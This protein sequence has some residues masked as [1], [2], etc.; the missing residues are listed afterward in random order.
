MLH[1]CA[2]CRYSSAIRVNYQDIRGAQPASQSCPATR[3][4]KIDAK[5]NI[6]L[7]VQ[8]SQIEEI[9]S[10]RKPT[11]FNQVGKDCVRGEDLNI[12][13]LEWETWIQK[14]AEKFASK[15]FEI[16]KA[17]LQFN[18]LSWLWRE[19]KLQGLAMSKSFCLFCF[20][21]TVF[22]LIRV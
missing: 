13:N 18:L 17:E 8:Q 3:E 7:P 1:G 12:L 2:C 20:I 16:E 14:K 10:K 5:I 4:G 9:R 6:G 15:K 22:T 11:R 21:H 19:R